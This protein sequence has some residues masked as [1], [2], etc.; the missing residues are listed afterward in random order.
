MSFTPC[1]SVSDLDDHLPQVASSRFAPFVSLLCCTFPAVRALLFGWKA[2][3]IYD[4]LLVIVVFLL[5]VV[6]PSAS[7]R[8]L[9]QSA[10][11]GIAAM[12]FRVASA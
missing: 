8:L 2:G 3:L 12:A 7:R 6:A 4:S 10:D 5:A 1:S 11:F 9:C